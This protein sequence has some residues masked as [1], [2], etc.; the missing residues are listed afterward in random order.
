RSAIS[1][2]GLIDQG[3]LIKAHTD[4]RPV[5]EQRADF[6]ARLLG[7]APTGKPGTYEYA[8]SNYILAG[9]AIERLVRTDWETAMAAEV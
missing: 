7:H 1:D 2:T 8:N 3:W 6:A 5:A 9:A 4:T